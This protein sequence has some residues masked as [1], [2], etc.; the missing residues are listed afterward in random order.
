[1]TTPLAEFNRIRHEYK[2]ALTKAS[3]AR[4]KVWSLYSLTLSRDGNPNW[5]FIDH[6]PSAADAA[7]NCPR[8]SYEDH[9]VVAEYLSAA[10]IRYD[11]Q[12]FRAPDDTDRF[13]SRLTGD[14]ALFPAQTQNGEPVPGQ[15]HWITCY[16]ARAAG[17]AFACGPKPADWVDAP[18]PPTGS[19][20]VTIVWPE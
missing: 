4:I 17:K 12:G 8:K 16:A 13:D 18:A 1:M 3:A 5:V 14:F 6:F 19:C 15:N 2:L 11:A 20:R 9:I 7:L 10:D